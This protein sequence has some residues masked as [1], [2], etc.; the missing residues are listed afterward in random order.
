MRALRIACLLFILSALSFA[1]NQPP[2]P[3]AQPASK[4]QPAAQAPA[5]TTPPAPGPSDTNSLAEGAPAIPADLQEIVR[6][7]FGPS[8][9]VALQ[10]VNTAHYLHQP[11]N[12]QQWSPLLVGDL[13]GDGVED[14]VIV[15]RVKNVFSGQIPFGYAV[16]DPYF[17]AFGY[18]NP[19]ATAGLA[20]ERPD[21]DY[22]VLVIH[23][24]GPEGWRNPKPKSKFVMINLPFNT[25]NVAPM[26]IAKKKKEPAKQLSVI[27]LEE[28]GT[29]QSSL[30]VWDGKT[31]RWR[32]M[33]GPAE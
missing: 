2:A 12:V 30:V 29:S 22:V 19:H 21:S 24:A 4:A 25:I 14:A 23:G 1:Q 31:Y 17:A 26:K 11:E 20:D 8:F 33:G 10:R 28:D 16:I 32:D 15:A 18:G 3:T 5:D 6:K 13:D 9:K 27:I 7:Q